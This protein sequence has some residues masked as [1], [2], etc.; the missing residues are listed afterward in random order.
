MLLRPQLSEMLNESGDIDRPVDGTSWGI[1]KRIEVRDGRLYW[2]IYPQREI[3]P[4]AGMFEAFYNLADGPIERIRAFAL[5]YGVLRICE[6]GLPC[7][8]TA[9]ASDPC[10]P[11]GWRDSR[12]D[13]S[14]HCWD[15]LE[16]W[17]TLARQA[18]ALTLVADRLLQAKVGRPED[19]RTIYSAGKRDAPWWK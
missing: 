13:G 6:H 15:P 19:W 14:L 17:T 10:Y 2:D 18:Q 8:H 4:S 3:R 12:P 7:S 11:L 1:P 16:T 9:A 5:K